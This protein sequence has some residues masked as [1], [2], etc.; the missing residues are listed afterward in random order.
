MDERLDSMIIMLHKFLKNDAVI[1]FQNL[2][3]KEKIN[4]L[5][6]RDEIQFPFQLGFG[7]RALVVKSYLGSG[8]YGTAFAAYQKKSTRKSPLVVK[9]I[10]SNKVH[11]VRR[12][13]AVLQHLNRLVFYDENLSMLVF[14]QIHG[15]DLWQVIHENS[16]REL[17]KGE[18]TK[19]AR[20]FYKKT[21]YIHGDVR[22]PNV[23]V[24]SKSGKLRLIDFGRS[25]VPKNDKEAQED[26]KKDEEYAMLE[27]EHCILNIKMKNAY[28]SRS[29]KNDDLKHIEAYIDSL[30]SHIGRS[31]Q[32]RPEVLK[33]YRY[34]NSI[35]R[36]DRFRYYHYL[37][38]ND[39]TNEDKIELTEFGLI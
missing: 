10:R 7:D 39:M 24:D 8:R 17:Y 30:I 12:E 38:R 32:V 6:N 5:L 27:Y 26:L 19:L 21:G 37:H 36:L 29:T 28:D 16:G 4:Q 33:Y 1:E 13:A 15:K 11:D 9:I 18:Y 23:I 31:D 3:L 22:P 34:L 20:E 2:I 35:G 25:F 14:T